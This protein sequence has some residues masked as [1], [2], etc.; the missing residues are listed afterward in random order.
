MA[1][2][3]RVPARGRRWLP[4]SLVCLAACASVHYAPCP[5]DLGAPLPSDA[6]S[7]CK[8]VLG[9]RFGGLAIADEAAFLLQS[10]WA[11]VDDRVGERRASVFCEGGELMVVVESRWLAEPVV[12]LPEWS[13]VRGDPAAERELAEALRTELGQVVP[14][15]PNTDVASV[16]PGT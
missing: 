16:R 2:S 6:F 8:R 5:V 10:A 14:A 7:V 1:L 4:W 3:P 15:A 13:A 9:R 12:G 11:P